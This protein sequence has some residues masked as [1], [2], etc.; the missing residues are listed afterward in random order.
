M[1]DYFCGLDMGTASLG[2]AVTD[3]EYNILRAH[4]KAL[5]GVRLF[6][7]AQT[8]E[9]RRIFR[10]ARRRLDRRNWRIDVLQEL[11]AEEISKVDAGFYLRMKESRYTAEDKRDKDGKCPLLPYA[12]FVDKEYTDKDYHK[13]FPTIYHLRKHLMTTNTVPDVRLVYLALHHMMKHRGH[14]LLSGNIESIK[15]FKGVFEQFV[16]VVRDEELDFHIN[17]NDEIVHDAEICLKN[18]DITKA[19]K[20]NML[21]KLFSAQS[22]CEK[23]ILGLIAGT[24]VSLSD[25]FGNAQLDNCEKPKISFSDNNYDEYVTVIEADLG[26]QFEIIALAKAVYDWSVLVEILG[27][28]HCISDA[29][30]AVYDKHKKDLAY[31]KRVVKNNLDKETYK[32]I[33]VKTDAK[34][35]NYS[36]YIGMTKLN[37]KKVTIEGKRCSREDFY[38]FLKKNVLEQI[39]DNAITEYLKSEMEKGTFLPR[40]VTKDNGVIPYQVHLQE[41]DQILR[42]VGDKIPFVK[43]NADKLRSIFTFRIPYYVGP[44]NGVKKGE[45]TTNW[46]ERKSRDKIYPWNFSEVVDVEKSAEKFILR[47]TNK[48]TYL[49]YED[50]LPQNSMLYSKFMVLNE[51]NNLKL[52]GIPISVEQKQNI[53]NDL[54]QHYRKVTV[55]KLKNYLIR[56]GIADRDVDITGIDGDF[57]AS[58][59]AY[60]DFKEKL[61]GCNLSMQDY[62]NII[63][64]ITLFGDDKKLLDHR[65]E[66]QYPNLTETQRKA[67]RSLSYKGWGRLS[68]TFL[69]EITAPAPETGEAWSIIQTLWYTND[70][71]MQILSDKYLF[72]EA[73]DS[74]NEKDEIKEISYSVVEQLNVSPAV[75]RQIWQTL[76][77]VRELCKVMKKAPKRIFVE[78]A[79]E[80]TDSKRTNSRKNQLI[81]LYKKCKEEE[82]DWVQELAHLQ[83]HQLRSDKLYLYYT[84][85]GR[86]MYSGEIIELDALWDNTKYDID[87]IYPQSKVMDDSLDNR[88][89]VKKTYNAD[90][91]D[92]YPIHADIRDKMKP[93]WKSLLLGGF[94]S[95][96][97]YDRLTRG[98]T[99]EP[100]E[101]AGFIARQIVETRQGT[102]V[103]ASLLKQVFPETEIVYSK[104][105]IT[106]QF[107]QDFDLIKVR[108]MN[109]LHHATDAY[110]NIVVGNTYYT[111]FT[112][113]AAW[114]IKNNPGRSYNLKRMFTSDSD[115]ARGG[116]I[117]WK[118]GNHGTICT[119]RKTMQKN[120]ILVTRRS[121]QEK[122]G[123][124]DQQLMKKG[125]G[126]VPVK[127][128]DERLSDIE[129]YGGYNKAKGTYFMLVESEDKKG[130]KIRTIEYVPLYLKTQIE[131]NGDAALQYLEKDRKLKKPRILL[132]KIKID[133]LFRVD[134]FYMWL[135]GRTENQLIFKGANQL[136]LGNE[137]TA[138]LKK[139]LKFVQRQKENKNINIV[140]HDA[141]G[142]KE[143]IVLYDTFLDKIQNTVYNTRLSKQEKTLTDKKSN[144]IELNKE[145]KCI[146]LSEILHMFQCQSATSN[147]K[148]IGGPARA[149]ILVLNNNITDCKNISIINQSPT[150]I[151]EREIDLKT[152]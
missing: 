5:W 55:K 127:G 87:H 37:G 134:G 101:L 21:C 40:Q 90:K 122:G 115:V 104:A 16:Q 60:H 62:E 103:V 39:Q 20:R 19:T 84:Q 25:V 75:K 106:S 4:G 61:T 69:E 83:D 63:L 36:E 152:L 97:K 141:L 151:Y 144:F 92:T 13:E 112:K 32:N 76:L 102:K 64:D 114:Y 65:L 45:C 88:V 73:V 143:L 142:D 96:E 46:V 70:N 93:F 50:V 113:N 133:T 99:F 105:K 57:K 18:K 140:E 17:M 7:S 81:D 8:A 146:V 117:A 14:F 100:D 82:K 139:V 34:V 71:L 66:I 91:T 26:E 42:N 145:D 30:I 68:R 121:Y 132:H 147:L 89:L 3:C 38:A 125:Q 56:E 109:D 10:T 119:V 128:H 107:R 138:I 15:A 124:F 98:T 52:N 95:K 53:Y 1:Q 28:H 33:F 108:E 118:A 29:K 74:A 43:A 51:L 48:C 110:L 135:S 136:I 22:S 6:D 85:K 72:A 12:L 130:N 9:E 59:T 111:K 23:A 79:R 120:N 150:G 80:K 44:L 24:K 47:M 41:L 129:K 11:F 27:D 78:M 126:Q 123:L 131:Q 2:W 35:S 31:L 116:E 67:L 49:L 54:F 148:L 86:C 94:I 149:G 77:V 58:L 137:E